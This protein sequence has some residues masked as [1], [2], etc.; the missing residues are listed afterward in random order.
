MK[1][2]KRGYVG[3]TSTEMSQREK[4]NAILAREAAA[5]GF[6]LLKNEAQTLPLKP[7]TKIGL[8]GAGAV[9]TIKGGT[10]SG[11]V[12]N[13]Y[14]VNI[15]D[16][17]KNAG[18]EITSGAWLDGYDSCYIQA[19]ENWKAEIFRK[20]N[21]ECDG[22]F[23]EAYSTTPFSMPAGAAVEEAAAKADGADVGIY[24][25]AR[26]AGENADRWDEPGD[27][28]ITEEERAQIAALCVA[29]E[30]VILVV[31]TGGLIDL[32]FTD[33][34]PNITA[35]LQ[36]VQAGQ[37]GGNALADVIS[38]KVT[39]SGKMTDTWALDYMD[40]PNA[41][42]FSH[43]SGDVYREEYREG[44]YVGYR[45]FDTFDVPVRY[46]FG[47]GLSYTEFDI[48]VTGISKQT[49][50]QGR[51]TLLVCVDVTNSG[52]VYAGKEVVQVYVSCPQGTLP[53]E[54]RRLAA[55][56]KTK[57]LAPGET[58]S[59][60]LTIDLY[61]L[62]SYSE[63]QAAWLLEAG[64][65]GIWT[66][67]AL[68]TA[69]LCGTFVLDEDKILVQCEHICPLKEKLEEL[70]PDKAKLEEK[71]N[72][73]M[74]IAS[75]KQLPQ[76][77]ISAKELLTETVVYEELQDHYPGKAGEIVDQ[78]S[79]E[80]LIALATGDPA[81]DQGA[82]ALGSAGQTV[83]GAAAETVNAAEKDP[84]NV[85]SIVLA[86][87]P[88]GLRLRSTYQVREDG[89]IDGG[90]FLDGFENGYFAEPKEPTG[91]VY[92]QYCTAIPVGTLLAQSWNPELMHTLGRMIA[93]EMNE[94]E[95][96]LWL[97]PGMSLHRNPLCGRNFEYYSEDPL[98]AGR[99][100]A[101]MTQGVQSVPGCGTTIK[102][103]A[104]N[105]QEDN[106]MG[107][108]SI[109]SERTLREIYLKGFEIAIRDAQPMAMMTSYNLINGVHA[110][111]NYDICTKAARDEW[112][113][114]GA[115]MTDWTT[116]TDSTA[117]ECT[118]AGCMKA[119]NDMV[120]PGDLRDHASIRQA[121]EDGSLDIRELK[122]CVYHTVKIILQSNQYEDAVSYEEQFN[123]MK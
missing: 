74:Q 71:Q 97:A 67:N 31:N 3:N 116:T 10:G 50:A 112:G 19:R 35:I 73:W 86:D 39:P 18:F 76:L 57:L 94:F 40:Y 25:L 23:F 54:Y 14:N 95:V 48:K 102:H 33:V 53:K 120:M 119:G 107:S 49:S 90:D 93:G 108:D 16:G 20:L 8:Y 65:Y 114:A 89:S 60:T 98:L 30:K 87:G 59:L 81:K 63:E 52:A 91:T 68:S 12:N 64:T 42:Y 47:Y 103:Y 4:D 55:F 7:G 122:R 105:N 28:Y 62:A 9:R 2:R 99:M 77:Q 70:Q 121:L 72:I 117:G 41:A 82:S 79:T 43:K 22:N 37:E 92:H 56:E 11:D 13:R 110:A 24:V 45:Y 115:I 106:R 88:A 83:P 85:A 69:A 101:A 46:S 123:Q 80:E 32:A 17:L 38:G 5:E 34:F 100:A 21:A 61:Q 44:I 113:F 51:R 29:Y 36:Y 84:Y 58:Q 1:L 104:C 109:L 15:Y 6:V 66:G 26:I 111:N 75:E 118:A 96:T 78:L 27:Y